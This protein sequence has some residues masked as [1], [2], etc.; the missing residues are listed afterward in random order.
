MQITS[1]VVCGPERVGKW[2][3]SNS[4]IGDD[5]DPVIRYLQHDGT[6]GKTTNYFDSKPEIE[7][8]LELGHR[9]DFTVSQQ[10]QWGRNMIR[11]DVQRGFADMERWE[12]ERYGGEQYDD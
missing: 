7:K 4:V 3:C 6:W 12:D 2:Y 8:L 1:P 11:S 9:T 5:G 10:E